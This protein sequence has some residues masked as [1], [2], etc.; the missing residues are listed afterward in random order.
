MYDTNHDN[1][2]ASGYV[3]A[4]ILIVISI[5]ATLFL[6]L[7][8]QTVID[9]VSVWQYQPSAAITGF[10]ERTAMSEQGKFLFFA[11]RPS[12]EGTQVFNEKCSRTEKSTAILGCYD[13]LGSIYIYDVP[14]PKLDGIREV[15]SA[16]EMLH[17]AYNRLNASER[18][19]VDGLVEAEYAKLSNNSE[20]SAR[21]AFY[22]RTEPGERDN[23][24]HSIIGTEVASV[25][26]ELEQYYQRYF[27]VRSKVVALHAQYATVF[28]SLQARSEELGAQLTTLAASIES[29]T[30]TYNSEVNRLNQDIANFNARA[31]SGAFSSQ[32]QFNSERAQLTNRAA[33]LETMRASIN[34]D[35]E[36]YEAMRAELTSIASESE[37]LNKSI[38]SSLAP[39]P[40]L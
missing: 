5:G 33:A 27:V 40:S 10:A 17:A 21:M 6:L 26:P 32:A 39:A 29:Q 36:Q 35:R 30:A 9:H 38:D 7:N 16:H 11:S 25:S 31:S 24:L 4:L 19:K 22:A 1:R 18:K 3:A 2:R 28:A 15:T 34:T 14:N 12:L 20:F 23:E 13:G 8:R 37:A